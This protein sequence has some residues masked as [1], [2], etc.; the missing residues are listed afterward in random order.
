MGRNP[1]PAR[2]R[3]AAMSRL[4]PYIS[5][6]TVEDDQAHYY[7]S[8]ALDEVRGWFHDEGFDRQNLLD[9]CEEHI[10]TVTEDDE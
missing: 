9:L 5:Q 4:A 6:A 10:D 8:V 1:V 2:G 3:G 7:A